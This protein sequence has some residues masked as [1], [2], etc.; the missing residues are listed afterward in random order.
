MALSGLDDIKNAEKAFKDLKRGAWLKK[1]FAEFAVDVTNEVAPYPPQPQTDY[2]RT[3]QLARSWYSRVSSKK[4]EVGNRA[5]YAAYVHEAGTQAWFHQRT[6]WKLFEVGVAK[7]LTK[8][9]R[10]INARFKKLM[11]KYTK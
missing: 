7:S 1:P 9:Q 10:K 5:P 6:G 4:V 11:R 2:R 3:R 8:M